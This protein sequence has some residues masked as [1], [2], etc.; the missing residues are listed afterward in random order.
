MFLHLTYNDIVWRLLSAFVGAFIIGMDR[1]EHGR[2]VGLR[3]TILVCLAACIAMLQ[4]N[5]LLE[6]T[7]R[8]K[9]S[10]V[11]IDVMRMPLGILSGMGFIGGGAILR[12][13]KMIAGVT[14]AATL[15]YM[16]V[17]GLCF[18]GGQLLLGWAGIA[19]AIIVLRA[20]KWME[21]S[22]PRD[23]NASL[24]VLFDTKEIEE[25]RLH[26]VLTTAKIKT[27]SITVCDEPAIGSRQLKWLIEWDGNNGAASV[28]EF[29]DKLRH[30]PGLRRV[31]W[32]PTS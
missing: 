22:L 20:L 7:G 21:K 6:L 25:S 27:R 16:T 23:V 26:N 13:D 19:I 1:G 14:T 15:W 10:F 28:P 5:S 4:S 32:S 18:G 30:L 2:A 24:V 29:V 11:V 3:T 9:D 12:K 17:I 31:E 8:D